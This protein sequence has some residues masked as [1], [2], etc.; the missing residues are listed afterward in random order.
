MAASTR[1]GRNGDRPSNG[2]RPSEDRYT[3][4]RRRSADD[5]Y[6]SDRRRSADDRYGS[7][8]RRSSDDGYGSDRRRSSDDR[9]GSDRR[10]Q[11][12]DRYASDRRRPSD[13]RYSADRRRS[14]DDRY[15]TDRR[16]SADDR[17]AS[18]GRRSSDRYGDDR[19]S[20]RSYQDDRYGSG[21]DRRRGNDQRRKSRKT[22]RVVLFTVE[23]LALVVLGVVLWGVGKQTAIQKINVDEEQIKVNMN[24]GV[25][26]NEALKGYRNIALFGI[27][28]R[29]D[30]LGKGNRSDTIMVASLNQD[31][32]EVKLVSVYRDTYMNLGNDKYNKC[33]AAYAAGGPEQAILML[34]SN[35]DLNITDYIS[36][37]FKGLIDAIDSLGG[38]QIDVKEEEIRHLNNYQESM[39]STESREKLSTDYVKVTQ[40]GLQTLNGMQATAYCRIRYTAG[41]D[42]RR[43][44]RQRTVL[45][46]CLEKAKSASIST[47]NSTLDKVLPNVQTNLDTAEML[48]VL[49]DLA[50]YEVVAND[51]FPFED[52]RDTG[53][54]SVGSVVIPVSLETNVV[55]LHNFLFEEEEYTPSE[56]VKSYSARISNDTGR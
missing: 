13:D 50:K 51:G 30:D 32:G 21:Q 4:D 39:F 56:Q 5:R 26:E 45:L 33:N 22:R 38:V 36:V 41:D 2:R 25:E 46:A 35:L 15:N 3:S 49:S 52:S 8:R 37:G 44:E 1:N 34:N 42:F 9:Y 11:S 14:A 53:K 12:D 43:A 48:E 17:Y 55:K 20:S 29:T 23:I 19:R 24:E 47:L 10:R 54:I 18:E 28:S 7:D 16:R 40:P 31:T 27:D 6:G